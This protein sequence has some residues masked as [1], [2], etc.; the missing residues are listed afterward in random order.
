MMNFMLNSQHD[1]KIT[2]LLQIQ[3]ADL[4]EAYTVALASWKGVNEVCEKN[5]N[6]IQ[7]QKEGNGT[8]CSMYMN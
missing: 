7:N 3:A 4:T 1:V 5:P 6:K 2:T 8:L